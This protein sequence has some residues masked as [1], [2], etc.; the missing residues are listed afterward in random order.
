[1]KTKKLI[2]IIAL[3][4]AVCLTLSACLYWFINIKS[5]SRLLPEEK[6]ITEEE[7]T[8]LEDI[9]E[10][11]WKSYIITYFLMLFTLIGVI[12]IWFAVANP[13]MRGST[14]AMIMQIFSLMLLVLIFKN[15]LDGKSKFLYGDMQFKLVVLLMLLSFGLLILYSLLMFKNKTDGKQKEISE[16]AKDRKDTK[17][18]VLDKCTLT[19]G[20]IDFAPLDVLGKTRY[21]DILTK[22]QIIENCKDANVILCNKAVI[23]REI[24]DNCPR[25]SYIG[26]FAT[27]YNNIDITAAKERN[28]TVCNAPGYST[29]SVAQLVFAYILNHTTSLDKY[30][31]STHNGEWIRSTAFSYFP[32]PINELSGK[33]LCVIGYGAIGKKVAKLGDAFGMK[34]RIATRTAPVN[35]PYPLIT[36]DEAFAQADYLTV[37]CPLTE[38]TRGL[39]NEQRLKTMKPTAYVINTARGAVADEQ[40]LRAAL[41]AGIISGAACD[42]LTVEPMRPDDALIGANNLTLTPHIAW[43]SYEARVRLIKLV[44][45]NL[46]A[47]QNGLPV[48]TVK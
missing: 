46:K 8:L 41:D 1:M 44:A 33:T 22:E 6:N 14:V 39:I 35:C 13:G 37:H 4:S 28:I 45:S 42:V 7:K 24:M 5:M 31:E 12:A 29:D 40:A 23:D 16:I 10:P 18:V 19:V 3:L 25:L 32:Y 17:I 2:V 34:V 47:Y 15:I 26:L 9:G 38:Q 36:V 30:N 27:G 43:A 20:D 48:N 11:D 21:F